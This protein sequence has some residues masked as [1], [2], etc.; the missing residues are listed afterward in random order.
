[1]TATAAAV[2]SPGIVDKPMEDGHP[3]K[4]EPESNRKRALSDD[5]VQTDGDSS[6]RQSAAAKIMKTTDPPD[7]EPTEQ[8]EHDIPKM[9]NDVLRIEEDVKMKIE[10]GAEDTKAKA[11]PTSS[12]NEA[13][14][15]ERAPG[16][17][18]DDEKGVHG[19]EVA[20]VLKCVLKAPAA[21]N[22]SEN[23]GEAPSWLVELDRK[24]A[25]ATAVE[26]CD[27][28][29]MQHAA[30][31]P[32]PDATAY[33]PGDDETIMEREPAVATLSVT[34]DTEELDRKPAA[35]PATLTAAIKAC[36]TDD[37]ATVMQGLQQETVYPPSTDAAGDGHDDEI[38]FVGST[39]K[40]AL[41]D[42]PHSREHCLVHPHS[43]D[44][45]LHCPNCFCY[46]CDKLVEECPSWEEH[47]HAKYADP[48][49]RQARAA[50]KNGYGGVPNTAY[51]SVKQLLESV[52]RI[53]PNEVTPPNTFVTKLHHYQ[54]QSLAFLLDIEQSQSGGQKVK[55]GW[56]CSEVGM[57]K[58]AVVIALVNENPLS[59]M[60][61]PSLEAVKVAS[62]SKGTRI[63]V[64]ATVIFTA[65][66]LLGQWEDE[67]KKHAPSLTVF[68][69][70]PTS[71]MK[72]ANLFEADIV[73]TT[74][75]FR[76]APVFTT[77]FEFHRL[78]FDES[79]RIGTKAAPMENLMTLNSERN[80]CVTATPLT[81]SFSD[82]DNQITFL[83]LED[84]RD[85]LSPVDFLNR[86]MIRHLKSQIIG[87][88]P[89][90]ALPKATTRT[91]MIPMTYWERST[92][93]THLLKNG[94]KLL[95]RYQVAT[96]SL[97]RCWYGALLRPILCE[98]SSKI[99]QMKKD[100][101]ELLRLEPNMRVVVY[102]QFSEQLT[103]AK[104]A[105]QSMGVK[106]YNFNGTLAPDVCDQYIR[107]FQSLDGAGPAVFLVTIKSGSVGITL[108]AA[109][110]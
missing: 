79:H 41:T 72:I 85:R 89:A 50:L 15:L 11:P 86:Y 81:S 83:E 5:E 64:K 20:I 67:V 23:N 96:T 99:E 91:K 54:R 27:E 9:E 66:S 110:M 51:M 61:H 10:D 14:G 22:P 53:F 32:T 39:G 73:V 90:L 21:M 42:F 68:R 29:E 26:S 106:L 56:L 49:W 38:Q 80:I 44:P 3:A 98:D 7:S 103:Y 93:N 48:K 2:L 97:E 62:R 65:D 76:W 36:D 19:P 34:I 12:A 45:T 88:A 43:T 87:G 70:H 35:V 4:A 8:R 40:N 58:S 47:C 74:A 75:T 101:Q 25:A 24:P 71:K 52:V 37:E 28:Q 108:N 78:V 84:E 82:L 16:I 77:S 18:V 104:R 33:A 94:Q 105:V 55:S 57:G 46:V 17:V 102:S 95:R 92:F 109:S 59:E 63:K 31:I 1:M 107:E 100:L 60:Q 30:T 6:R 13:L 69:H